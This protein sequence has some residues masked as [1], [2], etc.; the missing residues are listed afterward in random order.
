MSFCFP[1]KLAIFSFA[2]VF[3]ISSSNAQESWSRFRGPT[4]DGVASGPVPQRWSETEGVAW[5][6]PVAGKGHSSPVVADGKVWITTGITEQLSAEEKAERFSKIKD[7]NGLDLVGS[8]SQRLMA[9]DLATG[10]QLHDIEVFRTNKPEPIHLTNTYASPT[11][12]ISSRQSLC[13]L[14]NL[15]YSLHR[16]EHGKDCLAIRQHQN[17][18]SKRTWKFSHRLE[19]LVDRAL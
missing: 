1:H 3:S 7:P 4:G 16:R 14:R 6:V 2:L 10:N 13:S 19:R 8:L 11:P 5:K 9:Y 12:V 18:S 17:R 15:W